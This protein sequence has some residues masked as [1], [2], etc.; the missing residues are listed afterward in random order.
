MKKFAKITAVALV[1]V[2]ALAALVACGPASDPKKAEKALKD[3]KYAVT[4]VVGADGALVQTGLDVTAKAMGL[5]AGDLIATV[6]AT[7][8]E[9]GIMIYYFK[10]ASVARGYWNDHKEDREKLLEEA[11][12]ND[13]DLVIKISGSMIYQGTSQAVKDAR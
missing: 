5:E 12:K 4:A 9:E 11:K 1:A 7:N 10:N 8:G 6:N 13:K 3:K 2:L